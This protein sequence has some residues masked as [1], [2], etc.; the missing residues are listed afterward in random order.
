MKEREREEKERKEKVWINRRGERRM[1]GKE[2]WSGEGGRRGGERGRRD[3]CPLTR[4]RIQECRAKVKMQ[5]SR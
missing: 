3:V 5:G 4:K 2:G 1:G